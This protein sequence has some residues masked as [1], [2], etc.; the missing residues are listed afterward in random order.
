MM[1][2]PMKKTK[3]LKNL[4]LESYNDYYF[5]SDFKIWNANISMFDDLG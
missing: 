5:V 4:N 2:T 1:M 3:R